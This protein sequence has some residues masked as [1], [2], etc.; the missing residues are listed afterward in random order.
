MLD[1]IIST[2]P[3]L[4]TKDLSN[5]NFYANVK[6]ICSHFQNRVISKLELPADLSVLPST[7]RQVILMWC[8]AI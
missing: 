4:F 5:I 2:T 6:Y 8:I 1:A 7:I 3:Y